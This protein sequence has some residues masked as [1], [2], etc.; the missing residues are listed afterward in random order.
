MGYQRRV[1]DDTLDDLFP[2]LAAIALEGA[3]G[4]GKT[5]TGRQRAATV[6]S[7][8]DPAQREALQ[9]HRNLINELPL[10]LLLDEWQLDPPVWDAVKKSVDDDG[11][12]GRFL[13]AGSAGV[14]PGV[15]IHSGAGRIVRLRMRPL[16]L[17]ERGLGAPTVSLADMLGDGQARIEGHSQMS[18]PAYVDEIL[19][20]GFPGVRH[21]PDRARSLQ[22]DSY[23]DR[24]IDH[25]MP[26]NGVSVRRPAALRAW[27]AAYAAATA[28]DT[29]YSKILDAAT[30]GYPEKPARGTVDG[31]R[32]QLTRLFILD[33]VPAWIPAFNPL[34]RLTLT[35]KHHLVDPALAARL[36]GLKKD[37]L[38]TGVQPAAAK[39]T[40]LG[41]L[42]ES[43][44][45]QSLRV[46]AE[47]LDSSVSHART[48]DS[49]REIDLLV[50]GSDG[51]VVAIEVKLAAAVS[52]HD[53][54]HLHWLHAQIGDR[55]ADRVVITTGSSAYRRADGV[56]VVPLALLGP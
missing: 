46:Y 13:L 40:W 9:A 23:I 26:E 21:L 55:L 12:G 47:C 27:L 43:L 39:R 8:A 36:V 17:A 4:V 38:L 53:V 32:E 34:K 41:A 33:P 20:S 7:L 48:K 45:T 22:L 3:K 25:D 2:A 50:E 6:L 37:S 30:A 35:P 11:T 24:V 52:D 31:Y 49:A 42:F 15:R 16:A 19:A 18:L 44:V 56:A 51:R 54:R 10:P 29:S 1:V 14:A 28:T 5:E